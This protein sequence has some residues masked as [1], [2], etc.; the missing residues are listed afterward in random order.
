MART[1]YKIAENQPGKIGLT[2]TDPAVTQSNVCAATIGDFT[3]LD[4]SCQI[5]SASIPVSQN[6]NR[7]EIPGT[8]C[9]PTPES[10]VASVT[11]EYSVNLDV[12]LDENQVA[13][14]ARTLF[15]HSGE[16]AWIYIGTD[17]DDPPKAVAEVRVVAAEIFGA[18]GQI[19]QVSVSLPVTGKPAVCFGDKT[20]SAGV[21]GPGDP[22]D[23]SSSYSAAAA[24]ADLATLKADAASGDSGSGPPHNG[25]TG[26]VAAFTAGTYIVLA[27]SSQ[28]HWDGSAW[29]AGP[30]T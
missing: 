13:G 22:N 19:R 26:T 24:L 20:T 18:P 16:R 17:G 3:A 28:A 15:E 21:G 29:V 2:F 23:L 27:D 10:T 8:Y 5:I 30:A 11:D 25:G 4:M 7:E 12:L 9:E 1:A 14:V 6:V